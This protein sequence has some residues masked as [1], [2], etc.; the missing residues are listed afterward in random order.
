MEQ[1]ELALPASPTYSTRNGSS[2]IYRYYPAQSE[3]AMILIHGISEDSKYLYPLAEFVSSNNLAKVYTPD[4]RGYGE[5]PARRGD[6]DYIGQTE[7]DLA[8]FV[9]QI[10]KD[11]AISKII[12]AGHSAGGGTAIRFM[13]GKYSDLADACL[14][15]APHLG[16]GAPTERPSDGT[17]I[18]DMKRMIGLYLLNALGIRR[19]NGLTVLKV[20]RPEELRHGS[21]TLE[22]SY[23]LMM[24]RTLLKYKQGLR[25][26]TKPAF[27]LVGENDEVFY[28]DQYEPV[29]STYTKI[30]VEQI[31]NETHDGILS[32]IETHKLV[33]EWLTSLTI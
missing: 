10:R 5:N 19:W 17:I 6:V 27:V 26:L 21:E 3:S 14:L 25:K 4:L 1:I 31:S 22:M 33:R 13:T 2:L 32:N 15:L 28:A 12:I 20:D 24:S 8:D 29:F 30:K 23:R 16:P 9:Q 7:D 18:V 11:Q